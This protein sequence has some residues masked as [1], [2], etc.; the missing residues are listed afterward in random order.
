[1]HTVCPHCF[2]DLEKGSLRCWFCGRD[3]RHAA[4][5]ATGL[6]VGHVMVEEAPPRISQALEM[7]NRIHRL[8]PEFG[9]WMMA[10]PAERTPK[11]PDLPEAIRDEVHH[12]FSA[13]MRIAKPSTPDGSSVPPRSR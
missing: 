12:L 3:A 1:M 13:L 5:A 7:M 9:E 6:G 8:S 10:G 2:A 11:P 4:P